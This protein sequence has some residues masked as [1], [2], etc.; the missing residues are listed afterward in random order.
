MGRCAEKMLAHERAAILERAAS[1]IEADASSIES[2]I[3]GEA[4]IPI[5]HVK[6]EVKRAVVTLRFSAE[7]SKRI[8]GETIP[9]DAQPRS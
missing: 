6:V 2:T 5:K 1:K 3:V 9:F 7:E 8:G 4:G